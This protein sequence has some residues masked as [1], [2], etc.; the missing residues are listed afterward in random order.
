MGNNVKCSRLIWCFTRVSF[1][2]FL[3]FLLSAC[4]SNVPKTISTTPASSQHIETTP[5][6][7]QSLPVDVLSVEPEWQ[8]VLHLGIKN[9]VMNTSG[10]F[11]STH[12]YQIIVVC[13]G[14][15][16]LDVTFSPQGAAT[17]ICT[18]DPVMQGDRLETPQAQEKVH[19]SVAPQGN[20]HWEVSVQLSR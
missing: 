2:L 15:G 17:F 10:D 20:V 14:T 7:P 3:G 4:D 6:T 12:P 18:K 9:G 5:A 11:I 8:E 19:V 16:S 13:Q 1:V